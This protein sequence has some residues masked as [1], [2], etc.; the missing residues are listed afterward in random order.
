VSS[1]AS[2]CGSRDHSKAGGRRKRGTRILVKLRLDAGGE[3]NTGC[4]N[5]LG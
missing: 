2:Q 5:G 3:K 4:P 1:A